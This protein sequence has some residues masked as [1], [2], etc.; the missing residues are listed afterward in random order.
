MSITDKDLQR[1]QKLCA[2]D[3]W[4]QKEKFLSQLSEIINF[5]SQLQG[6][7]L[8][9]VE[10]LA[11]PIEEK[12]LEFRKGVRSFNNPKELLQNVKHPMKDNMIVIK[13]AIK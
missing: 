13:S 5:V 4:N 12:Q 6:L 11:H 3:L 8:E 9:W 7:D 2:I 1:L 10:P